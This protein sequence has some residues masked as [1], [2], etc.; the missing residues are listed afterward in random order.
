M[1][2][3]RE[4]EKFSAYNLTF[5]W[6]DNKGISKES[7]FILQKWGIKMNHEVSKTNQIFLITVLVSL[8]ASFLPISVLF[9]DYTSRLLFSE[10]ILVAPGATYLLAGNRSYAKAV[11]L[12]PLR[13]GTILWLILFTVCIMPVMGMVNAISM[14]FV[15]NSTSTM[16][17]EIVTGNSY[18][19]SMILIALLPC[20]FEE[21]V[22]RGMFYNE[23]RKVSPIRGMLLSALLFGLMHGN[24]NQFSYAFFMGIVFAVAIEATDSILASMIMHFLINGFS[25][26]MMFVMGMLDDHLLQEATDMTSSAETLG[27]VIGLYLP[28]AL[29]GLVF[30]IIVLRVMAAGEGRLE[31]IDSLLH[32]S[33]KKNINK[34]KA[35]K[36]N[37]ESEFF[38]EEN[39]IAVQME[40]IAENLKRA[41][42]EEENKDT[43]R[44]SPILEKNILVRQRLFTAPLIAG[45]ILCTILMILNEVL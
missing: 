3:D 2:R 39:G 41:D 34:T 33:R 42:I 35:E 4:L 1:Q 40:N 12:K 31:Y 9:P 7:C 6:Y 45:I 18:F 10:L 14:L 21:S 20:I 5:L 15:E 29:V 24:L 36:K 44:D 16:M 43:Q 22:Y 19:I 27:S 23:Y 26:T 30:A 37:I 28:I 17:G 11:R 8:T 32:L 13:I 38:T 25:T